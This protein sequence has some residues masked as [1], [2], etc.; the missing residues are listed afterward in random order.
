MSDH[1]DIEMR[2][3]DVEREQVVGILREQTGAGRLTLQEFEDRLGEVYAAK[4]ERDLQHVLRE[5]P[6]QPAPPPSAD[7]PAYRRAEER[8]EAELHQ[9]WRRRLRGEI[10]GFVMPNFVCNAIYFM[11]D[12]GYWWP[13]WVLFATGFGFVGTL[14]K[15]FDPD[16]ERAKLAAEERAQAI[17][18]IE[19][20]R[21]LGT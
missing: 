11:G 1:E 13:G 9:R 14:V 16:A 18:D 12:M 17:A 5:L 8:T 15:G 10:A 6:V 2:V 20:R 21:A 7:G 19:T 3:S 4:T